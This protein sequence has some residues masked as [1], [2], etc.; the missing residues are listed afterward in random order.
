MY[1]LECFIS[2]NSN[3]SPLNMHQIASQ[4]KIIH[5]TELVLDNIFLQ[6]TCDS[7]AKPMT[8]FPLSMSLMTEEQTESA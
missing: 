1:F 8:L 6:F 2:I 3:R 7:K 5:L 4:G